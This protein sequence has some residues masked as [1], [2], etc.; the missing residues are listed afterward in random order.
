MNILQ[1]NQLSVG[2]GGA[3]ILSNLSLGFP[4]GEITVI[5]GESGCGK[6]TLLKTL[7][8]LQHPL[9][10]EL[11]MFGDTIDFTSEESLRH[12]YRR[13]GV[14]YQ[15]SAL[16]NAITL[17]ENVALPLRMHYRGLPPEV[18][19]QMVSARLAQ[20]DLVESR[21]K[22]PSELSGGMRKRGALARAI[23][24]S[25]DIV[26]CDEPS[27]GL[28]PAT[29]AE[30]DDLLLKLKTELGMTMIVVTHELRS[31]AKIAD[32]ALVLHKGRVHF[33]GPR[34]DLLSCKDPFLDDFFLKGKSDGH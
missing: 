29:S 27:A 13:I 24:L 32:R 12:L 26:F 1:T 7:I 4:A 3:E 11:R 15:G 23:I 33:W 34:E 6:S 9:Q 22:Y 31:I 21:D 25:P 16:L 2:Y 10:G 20:V 17:Y 14:L 28:D 5:L 19:R 18:E 30:I 8:G